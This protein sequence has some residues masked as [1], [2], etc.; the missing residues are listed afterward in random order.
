MEKV[1]DNVWQK[2]EYS[3]AKVRKNKAEKKVTVFKKM[4]FDIAKYKKIADFGAGGGYI[5]NYLLNNGASYESIDLFDYSDNAICLA[6]EKIGKDNVNIIQHDLNTPL[7]GYEKKYDLIIA[8]GILEHLK[9]YEECLKSIYNSLADKGEVIL[10]WSNKS[11]IFHAEHKIRLHLNTWHYG[12]QID[13]N[14]QQLEK[15]LSEKFTII[16][17]KTVPCVGDK[18]LLTVMDIV[19]NKINNDMGRYLFYY[20]KKKTEV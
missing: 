3:I 8:F 20:I 12:Y 18:G 19:S 11:S 13:I 10:I 15:L 7:K 14:K 1:W 6:R 16:N 9:N 17:K 2:D 5:T 4:G